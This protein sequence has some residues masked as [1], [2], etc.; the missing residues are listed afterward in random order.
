MKLKII[1]SLVILLCLNTISCREIE[2]T[3]AEDMKLEEKITPESN[4]S[5]TQRTDSIRNHS[6]EDNYPDPPKTGHQW[7][8]K[9]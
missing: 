1:S 2:N 4:A 9:N 3:A 5:R 7:R 8:I 6:I